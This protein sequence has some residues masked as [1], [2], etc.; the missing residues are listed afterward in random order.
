MSARD[1][2]LDQFERIR[3]AVYPAVNA[4]TFEELAFRPDGES[5]SISW[6]VWHLTRVQDRTVASLMGRETVW[7]ANGWFARFALDLDPADT[8]V[9]HDPAT[10]AKVTSGAKPLLDYFEDVHRRTVGWLGSLDDATLSDVLDDTV[11]PPVTVES[12]LDGVIADNLQHVG[13]AAYVRGLVQR[14]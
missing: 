3:D 14:R 6:L 1:V 2:L 12:T 10:V 4:L 8:G 13:Q 7:T 11:Q 5:N 9:G